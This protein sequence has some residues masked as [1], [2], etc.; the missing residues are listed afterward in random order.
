MDAKVFT[1]KSK[2]PACAAGKTEE[3]SRRGE[4]RNR[5][6]V[7]LLDQ[8]LVTKKWRIASMYRRYIHKLVPVNAEA[9]I[10]TRDLPLPLPVLLLLLAC[11]RFQHQ[12]FENS[13]PL[14]I[15][16]SRKWQWYVSEPCDDE[17]IDC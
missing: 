15:P 12:V 10:I 14:L 6:R 1:D 11:G 5:F 16:I 3:R 8:L 7:V 17:F 13:N 2:Y 9:Q 4:I